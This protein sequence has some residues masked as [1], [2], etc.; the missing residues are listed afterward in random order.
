MLDD[1][2][3]TLIAEVAAA[4]STPP[5]GLVREDNAAARHSFVVLDHLPTVFGRQATDD[6]PNI[7]ATATCGAAGW[8]SK[9]HVDPSLCRS[10]T[11]TSLPGDFQGRIF[12][13]ESLLV[14]YA[15]DYD[16][17]YKGVSMGSH[18]SP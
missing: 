2:R 15:W 10:Q 13:P 7:V 18:G 14:L 3:I 16:L 12:V 6:E 5:H 11:T 1:G 4:N 9:S 8:F 17:V